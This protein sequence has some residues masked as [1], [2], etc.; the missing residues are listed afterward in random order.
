[1][2]VQM[3]SLLLLY[4]PKLGCGLDQMNWQEIVKLL[5]DIFAYADI[6]IVVY[7][8]Q[9]NGVHVLSA[10]GDAEFYANDEIERYSEECLL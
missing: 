10:E 9:E 2:Q 3:L 1:M 5:R 7:T 6:Q 8:L 4:I